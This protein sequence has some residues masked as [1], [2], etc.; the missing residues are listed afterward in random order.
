MPYV[1]GPVPWRGGTRT[2]RHDCELRALGYVPWPEARAYLGV[3]DGA[4]RAILVAGGLPAPVEQGRA[5]RSFKRRCR[6]W[7]E[8]ARV[9]D[10]FLE[11]RVWLTASQ[12]ARLAGVTRQA[13]GRRPADS[14]APSGAPRFHVFGWAG[15]DFTDPDELR[16]WLVQ[17]QVLREG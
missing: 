6:L 1:A 12:A 9:R 5:D 7:F 10:L 16:A 15:R 4:L 8:S 17:H 14:R 2:T 3:S 13:M 11:T